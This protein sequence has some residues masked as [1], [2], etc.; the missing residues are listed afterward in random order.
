MVSNFPIVFVIGT[1]LFSVLKP[2]VPYQ[3]GYFAICEWRR[4]DLNLHEHVRT[5]G[6]WAAGGEVLRAVGPAVKNFLI[7][8]QKKYDQTLK[9]APGAIW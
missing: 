6:D 1:T 8:T 2:Q 9:V 7:E 5:R 4:K 3:L